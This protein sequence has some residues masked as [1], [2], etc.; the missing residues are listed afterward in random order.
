MQDAK[1]IIEN[2]GKRL[3]EVLKTLGEKYLQA[4]IANG[5]APV[6]TT[7]LKSFTDDAKNQVKAKMESL[8]DDAKS[9]L[10]KG[11]EKE[12]KLGDSK[13]AEIA[14]I[15]AVEL[16]SCQVIHTG[17]SYSFTAYTVF[18]VRVGTNK[19][20]SFFSLCKKYQINYQTLKNMHSNLKTELKEEKI[21][22]LP[23]DAKH[24]TYCMCL[25]HKTDLP[26]TE[27]AMKT[28]LKELSS[29]YFKAKSL[30]NTFYLGDKWKQQQRAKKIFD[31]AFAATKKVVIKGEYYREIDPFDEGQ[32]ITQLLRSVARNEVV[33]Q[34]REKIP[35]L[36]VCYGKLVASMDQL[37][38]TTIDTTMSTVWPVAQK[39]VDVAKEKV[40]DLVDKGSEK[41]V[42]AIKPVLQKI[43]ELVKSK[44]EK[45]EE[46]K[47]DNKE[48]KKKTE[49][50]DFVKNWRFENTDIGKQF[51][52]GLNN[53]DAKG[54]LD[55][56]SANLNSAIN[57]AIEKRLQDGMQKLLGEKASMEVVQLVIEHI[58]EQATQIVK[59]FTTITPLMNASKSFFSVRADFE[60]KL[61]AARGGGADSLLKAIDE[62]SL[63][64]WKT[65]PSIGIQLYKDM[66]NVKTQ[67]KSE[68]SKLSEEAVA[69]LLDVADAMYK[70][71]M[72]ALNSVR[73]QLVVKL[74]SEVNNI[75]ASDQALEN[76]L[77]STFRD[78][79]FNNVQIL[80][81]EAWTSVADAIVQSSIVQVI[82]KF[83]EIVWDKVTPA[84]EAIQALIPEQLANLGLKIEKL[85][86]SVAEILIESA[87][88][89]VIVKLTIKLEEI[90]FN[91][92]V[93]L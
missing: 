3:G 88:T 71:Q 6:F 18:C 90:L 35:K 74:K 22:D 59:R 32:A 73:T 9:D 82:A 80:V 37:L 72:K 34:M 17:W 13:G 58:A 19:D 7:A 53:E 62:G 33:P 39:T 14:D 2:A 4:V 92:A 26:G 8:L 78:L 48:M 83:D 56:L 47:D 30:P 64:F 12:D 24:G 91:Q 51:Y 1:N 23:P 77:R 10:G 49:V 20:G 52:N 84:L 40:M 21:A 36:P 81:S 89:W 5:L 68:L 27:A 65:L 93:S 63:A 87:T 57:D 46:K 25:T 44:L 75:A 85:A 31:E 45:K 67:I 54:A 70:F 43:V 86:H 76:T 11:D 38:L 29:K 55:K 61:K 60:Q 79:I 28:Y 42:E 15:F 69:P 41:L 66:E 50:G 16:D